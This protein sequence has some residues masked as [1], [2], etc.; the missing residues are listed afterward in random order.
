MSK[1]PFVSLST[2][3][4]RRLVSNLCEDKTRD[5]DVEMGNECRI[6]IEKIQQYLVLEQFDNA[7]TQ[8]KNSESI[9]TSNQDIEEQNDQLVELSEKSHNFKQKISKWAV[10]ERINM[11]SLDRLLKILKTH[12]CHKDLPS[13]ARTL[14]ETPKFTVTKNVPGGIYWHYGLKNGILDFLRKAK[15]FHLQ[16]NTTI[17]L[18]VHLD[19]LPVS[20]SSTNQLWPILGS[21]FKINYVFI[22]GLYHSLNVKPQ[23]VNSFLDDFVTEVNELSQHG[24]RYENKVLPFELKM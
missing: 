11:S 1:K 24:I 6:D 9:F 7:N 16:D 18:M 15:S 19:G 13:C 8:N 17:Q 12:D 20:K 21:F 4:R 23:E 3:H 5:D 10:E 14:L 2:R 22:I